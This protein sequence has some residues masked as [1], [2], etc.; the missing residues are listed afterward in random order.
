M[1]R[2][3][4]R[5]IYLYLLLLILFFF[6]LLLLILNHKIH[7][8]DNILFLHLHRF[9]LILFSF[10]R[11]GCPHR[12]QRLDLQHHLYLLISYL[13]LIYFLLFLFFLLLFH[14]FLQLLLQL[15]LFIAF[16]LPFILL[17]IHLGP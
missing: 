6:Q 12:L 11:F 5:V 9:H 15:L 8:I 13:L 2:D 4:F 10:H 1:C 16:H 3:L 17:L 7:L 14:L